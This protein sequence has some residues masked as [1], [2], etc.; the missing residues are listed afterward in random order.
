MNERNSS[1]VDTE[2]N[3][4]SFIGAAGALSVTRIDSLDAFLANSEPEAE[5]HFVEAALEFDLISDD[6][7]PGRKEGPYRYNAIRAEKV[8]L[9][10]NRV[11][12]RNFNK[13]VTADTVTF[14]LESFETGRATFAEDGLDVLPTLASDTPRV[15]RYVPLDGWRGAPTYS[16]RSSENESVLVEVA[17][18]E[19][20]VANDAARRIELDTLE[21]PADRVPGYDNSDGLRVAPRL[22]VRN[23]GTVQIHDARDKA[24]ESK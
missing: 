17:G 1:D 6:I 8:L 23:Y 10:L 13:L 20:E 7:T 22:D 16:V 3:R 9:P 11:E 18:K 19:I 5:T 12:P 24:W 2:V 21:I 14:G 4:R 15:T